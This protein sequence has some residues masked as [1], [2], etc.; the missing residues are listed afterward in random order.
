MSSPP[1]GEEGVLSPYCADQSKSKAAKSFT[2]VSAV[3][4]LATCD[5]E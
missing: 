2:L 1:L 5:K 3:A 4:Q